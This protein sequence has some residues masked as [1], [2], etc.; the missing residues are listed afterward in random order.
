MKKGRIRNIVDKVDDMAT[1]NDL[2]YNY[3]EGNEFVCSDGRM[4]V[5][6][7][8]QVE[9]PDSVDTSNLTEAIIESSKKDGDGQD[10]WKEKKQK[11]N[12]WDETI[13]AGKE[14]KKI[15]KFEW[16]F[17]KDKKI[18]GYKNTVNTNITAYN[19]WV[20]TNLGIPTDIQNIARIGSTMAAKGVLTAVA[21]WSLPVLL[22]GAINKAER[23]RIEKITEQDKQGDIKVIDM[24]TY[25][26]PTPGDEG[27]NI[28]T[29]GTDSSNKTS[30]GSSYS[31]EGYENAPG[32]HW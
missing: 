26:T 18:D 7:I 27:F 17:D 10:I 28:H 1:I 13:K 32:Y 12:P 31:R 19:N 22:G 16:N 23:E 29:N 25:N 4:S 30:S 11:V 5:N 14:K 24:M 8:C 20:E 3:Q 6:G 2:L 15:E 9:Q 21:P